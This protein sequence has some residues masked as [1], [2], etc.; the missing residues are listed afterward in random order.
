MCGFVG[1]L[2]NQLIGK[3]QSQLVAQI[4]NS[5]QHRGP[6]SQGN[7]SV[8]NYTCRFY[9]LSILDPIT[10]SDQPFHDPDG[11]FTILF[12]GE[13]YNFIDLKQK[14]KN[15]GHVF[16]TTSDTEVVL[17]GY[18][19]WGERCIEHF[20]GMFSIVVYDH[21]DGSLTL[22]RDHLGI[23]PLYYILN[24]KEFIFASEIKAFFNYMPF[25]LNEDVLLEY[26]G[27]GSIQGEQTLVQKI[28]QLRP[29]HIARV[30]R[31][32]RFMTYR[33]FDLRETYGQVSVFDTNISS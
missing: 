33:Y 14:L 15:S 25:S 28:K 4:G 6:D 9:R 17:K 7:Y 32:L 2:S 24:D 29:G 30:A 22:L 1:L 8:A 19:E 5:I 26:I 12:N 16:Q 18:V 27:F 3:E 20:S 31:D 23:K 21:K 11:Q 13:I 10:R